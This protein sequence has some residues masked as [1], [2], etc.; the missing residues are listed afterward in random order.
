[1]KS[2][3]QTRDMAWLERLAKLSNVRQGKPSDP[4]Y[5]KVPFVD[6]VEYGKSSGQ[7]N[8]MSSED[9]V[10]G[11]RS[12][13]PLKLVE[14]LGRAPIT[15]LSGPNLYFSEAHTPVYVNNDRYCVTY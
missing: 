6:F 8:T 11:S 14:C 5:L 3:S 13:P 9:G 2:S 12:S 10:S 1:M 7:E 15:V 4:P